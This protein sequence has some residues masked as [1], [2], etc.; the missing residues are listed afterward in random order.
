[1]L[2]DLIY[3]INSV[4]TFLSLITVFSVFSVINLVV[5]VR[6][7]LELTAT[8]L[9]VIERI[10]PAATKFCTFEFIRVSPNQVVSGAFHTVPKTPSAIALLTTAL[11]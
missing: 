1:M 6:T 7:P 11:Y 8:V 2:R 9:V 4:D 10:P 5:P 3:G